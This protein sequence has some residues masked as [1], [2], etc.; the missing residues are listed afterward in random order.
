MKKIILILIFLLIPGIC[1]G[2]NFSGISFASADNFL[3]DV[4][5][6]QTVAGLF[7]TT[8]P[9]TVD[10]GDGTSDTYNGT[11][12][13]YSHDYG[14]AVGTRTAI[15]SPASALTKYTMTTAGANV[16]FA[17]SDLPSGL[18]YFYCTGSNTISG[19]LSDLP[20]GITFFRCYGSNT[21]SGALSGLPSGVTTFQCYGSN[22]ISG[23]LSDLP[24]GLTYFYCTGSNTI[25]GALSDLPSGLTTFLCYGS[26]TISGALSGL[27]SGVTYFNCAGSNTISNYVTKTWT[28]KPGTFV[29]VPVGAGGLSEVEID[30]LF[31][32]FDADLTWSGGNVITLT[33]TNAPPSAASDAARTNIISEGATITTN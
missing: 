33:G 31:I 24:S 28:T 22:T 25:S 16:Q 9:V 15:M 23:A 2:G 32:D 29:V 8:A 12:Q 20:S 3:F 30:Q 1:W 13:A 27:P 4:V 6:T 21:I 26:N 7:S 10:W 19:A 14:D 18:T 17:L 5:T 11:D